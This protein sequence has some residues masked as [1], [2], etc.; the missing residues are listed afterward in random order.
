[1]KRIISVF[2]LSILVLSGCGSAS[3][4][5]APQASSNVSFDTIEAAAEG[6]DARIGEFE[7]SYSLPPSGGISFQSVEFK[8]EFDVKTEIIKNAVVI[9]TTAE[10]SS[11]QNFLKDKATFVLVSKDAWRTYEITS[12][13]YRDPDTN[14]IYIILT[15]EDA[16]KADYCAIGGFDESKNEGKTRIIFEVSK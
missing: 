8:P 7:K 16:Q 6:G 10:L 2:I 13:T 11:L 4:S 15:A 14:S 1:M 3:S 5:A 12:T 9:K